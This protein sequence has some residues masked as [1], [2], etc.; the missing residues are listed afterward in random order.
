MVFPVAPP[1]LTTLNQ[2]PHFWR[3]VSAVRCMMDSSRS[4]QRAVIQFIRAEGEH[5]SQIY[6]RMKEVC[7]EQCL[8][9]FT[10]FRW[11]QRYEAGRVNIKELRRPGQAHVVTKSATI[12][13]VDEHI[14]QR[15]CASHNPR[16]AWLWQTLYTVGAKASVRESEDGENGC[17]LEPAVSTLKPSTPFLGAGISASLSV[18]IILSYTVPHELQLEYC[19]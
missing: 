1:H 13:A 19:Y 2:Y 3:I 8:V 15:K 12:S 6:C 14:H 17:F 4:A 5:V 11:C 10:I 9:R 7:W 16:K 18:E